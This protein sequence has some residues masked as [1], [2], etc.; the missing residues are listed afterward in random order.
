MVGTKV[1]SPVI[2]EHGSLS[3]Q[4]VEI[5]KD[6]T[7]MNEQVTGEFLKVL[8]TVF[9]QKIT[10]GQFV[11]A[12]IVR[13]FYE[14]FVAEMAAHKSEPL[15][16]TVQVDL[17]GADVHRENLFVD[18]TALDAIMDYVKQETI[19]R[20]KAN[21]YTRARII[22]SIHGGLNQAKID[23]KATLEG[24]EKPQLEQAAGDAI[25]D[26]LDNQ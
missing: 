19:I 5:N 12:D 23:Y 18:P 24:S 6:N 22:D 8:Q 14:K 17:G 13:E 20:L 4:E 7:F 2:K 1:E 25:E 16:D 15:P 9:A 3:I 21:D 11:D 26:V 10:G